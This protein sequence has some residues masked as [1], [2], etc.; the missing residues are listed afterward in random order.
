MKIIYAICNNSG[1]SSKVSD[2]IQIN[3]DQL[4]ITDVIRIVFKYS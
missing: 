4:D 2:V 1:P 3:Y